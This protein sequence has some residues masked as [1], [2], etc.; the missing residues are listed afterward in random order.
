MFLC[1]ATVGEKEGLCLPACLAEHLAE[2]GLDSEAAIVGI[3]LNGVHAQITLQSS[4]A[5]EVLVE[6]VGGIAPSFCWTWGA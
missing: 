6:P 1:C 5:G 3:L 4:L 2:V